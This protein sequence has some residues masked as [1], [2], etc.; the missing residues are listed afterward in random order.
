MNAYCIH[1]QKIDKRKTP[2]RFFCRLC[3]QM[4]GAIGVFFMVLLLFGWTSPK[5]LP[6]K[7]TVRECF[8]TDA[9]V[10][11]VIEWLN[12]TNQKH[13]VNSGIDAV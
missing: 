1:K 7:E 8:T 9:D 13:T 6:L 11:P 12:Q 3:I 5:A 4:V 2:K 10:M